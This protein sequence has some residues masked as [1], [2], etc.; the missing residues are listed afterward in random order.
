MLDLS[1]NDYPCEYSDIVTRAKG[2]MKHKSDF[3]PGFHTGN[4]NVLNVDYNNRRL[5][6]YYVLS[7]PPS[8]GVY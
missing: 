8:A 3:T 7:M 4:Y 2:T 5:F 6:P 1:V